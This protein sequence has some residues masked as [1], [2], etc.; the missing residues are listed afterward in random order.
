MELSPHMFKSRFGCAWECVL[1]EGANGVVYR[2][3]DATA[4]PGSPVADVAVKRSTCAGGSTS[5]QWRYLVAEARTLAQTAGASPHVLQLLA[6]T[7]DTHCVLMATP[8][9]DGGTV[10]EAV[11]RLSREDARTLERAACRIVCHVARGLAALH[12]VGIA[13]RDVKPDNVLLHGGGALHGD[14]VIA[15]LGYARDGLTAGGPDAMLHATAA[16]GTPYTRAPELQRAYLL[17]APAATPAGGARADGGAAYSTQADCWSL[18]VLLHYVLSRGAWLCEL[19]PPPASGGGGACVDPLVAFARSLH[20]EPW[21]REREFD[22]AAR[23]PGGGLSAA[24]QAGLSPGCLQVLWGLLRLDPAHRWDARAVL[25]SEWVAS[26]GDWTRAAYERAAP[27]PAP[28]PPAPTS[29]G[30]PWSLWPPGWRVPSPAAAVVAHPPALTFDSS[31]SSSP[32]SPSSSLYTSPRSSMPS[33]LAVVLPRSSSGPSRGALPTGGAAAGGAAAGGTAAGAPPPLV[34]AA[35]GGG[36]RVRSPSCS[37][38]TTAQ[39]Q[40][41]VAPPPQPTT[42]PPLAL[43]HASP[44]WDAAAHGWEV[45]AAPPTW[46]V[47][48]LAHGWVLVAA[49]HPH[50]HP[51]PPLPLPQSTSAGRPRHPS[52]SPQPRLCHAPP[53]PLPPPPLHAAAALCAAAAGSAAMQRAR[54]RSAS[55]AM[56]VS[57]EYACGA[58]SRAPRAC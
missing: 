9:C 5:P 40:R 22:P 46:E 10:S 19:K 14:A 58:P 21:F 8:L 39:Q 1:G 6:F 26:H 27:V 45:M 37:S 30:L 35:G 12:A 28:V 11:R 15:D 57:V 48:L 2:A 53:P 56:L 34:V 16:V 24:V 33:P 36:G 25:A 18:G 43:L 49:P 47:A 32:S 50:P 42:P 51:H 29:G 20:A 52:P 54:V 13:H 44:P 17:P 41:N 23:V 7:I 4:P 55:G 3:R 38:T 31:S